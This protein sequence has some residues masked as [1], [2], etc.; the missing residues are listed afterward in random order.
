MLILPK[1]VALLNVHEFFIISN[2]SFF[3]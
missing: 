1:V 3:V 2:A